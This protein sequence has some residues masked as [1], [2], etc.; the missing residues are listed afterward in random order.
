[1]GLAAFLPGRP[2][3]PDDDDE[4]ES[5]PD[6]RHPWPSIEVT[7]TDNPVTGL[8]L[9]VDGS[10]LVELHERRTVPFGYRL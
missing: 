2:W 1:M 6:E 9:A 10:V 5:E 3:V 8:L 4:P 7:E